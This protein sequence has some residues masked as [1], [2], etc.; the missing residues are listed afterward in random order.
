MLNTS[1]TTELGHGWGASTPGVGMLVQTACGLDGAH[2]LVGLDSLGAN[3]PKTPMP[4]LGTWAIQADG[5]ADCVSPPQSACGLP[6]FLGQSTVQPRQCSTA[7][8]GE[9]SPF[10][11]EGSSDRRGQS[12][13][14]LMRSSLPVARCAPSGPPNTIALT[15]R[16][17]GSLSLSRA[18]RESR[19]QALT[20]RSRPHVQ[21][22]AVDHAAVHGALMHVQCQ[23]LA[24]FRW[25]FN[26]PS[27]PPLRMACFEG[28]WR[29]Q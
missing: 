6:W 1:L 10:V 24:S 23:Q 3:P 2:A 21:S 4:L 9:R 8:T 27:C 20:S 11:G 22:V 15:E 25:T 7:V 28:K 17:W 19:L 13:Q 18:S 14:T 16:V 29:A 26:C 5:H 12:A